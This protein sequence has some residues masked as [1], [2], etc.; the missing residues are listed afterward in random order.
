MFSTL[1]ASRRTPDPAFSRVRGSA[2]QLHPFSPGSQALRLLQRWGLLAKFQAYHITKNHCPLKML[3]LL[4]A[5]FLFDQQITVANER[6]Q[7]ISAIQNSMSRH[8]L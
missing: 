5:E 1:R 7:Y 2:L 3:S 4:G 6:Q 8:P